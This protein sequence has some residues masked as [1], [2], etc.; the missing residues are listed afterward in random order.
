MFGRQ[1]L[2]DK[3]ARLKAKADKLN[4]YLNLDGKFPPEVWIPMIGEVEL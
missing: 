3:N 2:T 4:F 1:R